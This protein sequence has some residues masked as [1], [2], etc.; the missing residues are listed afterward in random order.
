MNILALVPGG[1][2]KGNSP[3]EILIKVARQ[4]PDWNVYLINFTFDDL[5]LLRSDF[6]KIDLVWSDMDGSSVIEFGA[7][8]KKN[9]GMKFYAHGEWIPPY[10]VL[11]G[12]GEKYLC[13]N[14]LDLKSYYMRLLKAMQ[15]ADLVS[16]GRRYNSEG[17]F[18][19]IKDNFGVEFENAFV[20]YNYVKRYPYIKY[21]RKYKVATI[22]RL[23]KKKRIEDTV[24]AIHLLDPSPEF[25][26]IGVEKGGILSSY[27]KINCLGKF[28]DDTKIEVYRT[29][30]FA[31]QHWSGIPPAEAM[32]QYCPV[33]SYDVGDMRY[34][35]GDTIIWAKK[36]ISGI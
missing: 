35:Y 9:Y 28:D 25:D 20:R 5:R 23:D 19:W 6:S 7:K 22:A 26:I 8:F 17:S 33:V 24:K 4:R 30:L 3:S 32:T 11:E 29:A 18:G 34:H 13:G 10:R 1:Q 16:F 12:Y 15:T 21:N 2:T 36:M 31:V 27:V 14:E